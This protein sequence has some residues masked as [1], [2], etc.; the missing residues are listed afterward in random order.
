M[1]PLDRVGSIKT[2][3][4]V[5][6]V[7]STGL[8]LVVSLA[9]LRMGVL[10]R[11]TFVIGMLFALG[12]VQVLARGMTSPLRQMAVAARAMARGDY[13]K[14]VV[15]TSRDEVGELAAAFNTM[16]SDLAEVDA[17]RKRLVADVSHELRTPL[18][19]LRASLENMVDGVA[20]PDPAALSVALDQT[21]RLGRLVQQLLDLSRLEAG[22]VPLHRERIRLQS[23]VEGVVTSLGT[24]R[25]PVSVECADVAVDADPE[26]LHQVV[27]NLV[28]N[29]VRHAATHVQVSASSAGADTVAVEVVDDGPGVAPDERERVFDR[30]ARTDSAR[31]S[32]DGGS[33][34]GLSITRWIAELHGGSVRIADSAAGCRVVVELPGASR[35]LGEAT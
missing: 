16:A 25:V 8:G 29:A 20:Q 9:L 2:K 28:T 3:L 12:A 21:V 22:A 10:F 4:G 27:A 1:R 11:Y 26:R 34:L 18:T 15:A 31:A 33:G 17:Q 24:T 14:R 23:H 6:V 7:A 30:F 32:A 35:T 5:L 19:A 13:S